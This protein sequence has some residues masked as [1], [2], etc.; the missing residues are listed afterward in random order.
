MSTRAIY[1]FTDEKNDS[2]HVFK[3][4]DGYP[5]G[6]AEFISKAV[7]LAWPAPRFEPDEFAAAF[8]AANKDMPGGIR[9]CRTGSFDQIASSDI[10]FHYI[11]TTRFGRLHVMAYDVGVELRQTLIFDGTPAAFVEWAAKQ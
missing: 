9:L 11:V 4:H 10:E 3:H 6:A 8:I 7:P 2:H 1:T 5:A